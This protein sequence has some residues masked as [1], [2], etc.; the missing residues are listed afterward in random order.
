[1]PAN[2][3]WI[4][5]MVVTGCIVLLLSWG[6]IFGPK[7]LNLTSQSQKT[8]QQIYIQND[9][10]NIHQNTLQSDIKIQTTPQHNIND[11]TE[12][13]V[14]PNTTEPSKTKPKRFGH[15]ILKPVS[16][17]L[18][19]ALNFLKSI[20]GSYG[21]SIILLTLIIKF[22]LVPL[23]IK[24][25]KSMKK[26]QKIQPMVKEL[27][28]KYKNDKQTLSKETMTLYKKEGANPLAGCIPQL[29]QI[30]IFLALY[31]TFS[32]TVV[33]S[34]SSFLWAKDLATPDTIGYLFGIPINIFPLIMTAVSI[35]QMKLM[36]NS[37]NSA[38]NKM[39]MFMPIMMLIFFYSMPSGLT[40]YYTVS[41]AFQVVFMM[42]IRLIE[43]K[44]ELGSL[45]VSKVLS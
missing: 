39:M 22:I 34:N 1:M 44:S 13:F 21:L 12:T 9:Q 23:N 25:S 17:V 28:E 14:E 26:M 24:S 3:D 16:D 29:I 2:I 8:T 38:Q 10:H 31:W 33:L 40:L 15:K 19:K 37:G 4:A 42:I 27:Q 30:P 20:T 36:T 32:D 41:T 6:F 5:V 43:K 35:V 45:K 11:R 7:G 18:L